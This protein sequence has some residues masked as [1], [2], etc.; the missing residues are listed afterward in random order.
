MKATVTKLKKVAFNALRVFPARLNV[1]A[2]DQTTVDGIFNTLKTQWDAQVKLSGK[3]ETMFIA[4]NQ[5][6][7]AL[8]LLHDFKQKQ[9]D[10]ES[11]GF[12]MP[13]LVPGLTISYSN[14]LCRCGEHRTDC[15]NCGPVAGVQS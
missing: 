10:A 9:L 3:S 14:D 4:L 11:L 13:D 12:T 6:G 2:I 5:N 15:Q 8:R 1:F 7:V